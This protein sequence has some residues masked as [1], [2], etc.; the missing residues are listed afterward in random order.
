MA[1]GLPVVHAAVQDRAGADSFGRE[2][3]GSDSSSGAG[4]ADGH[5]QAAVLELVAVGAHEP[6][7]DVPAA[8]DVA[9]VALVLLAHVEELDRVRGE[10]RLELLDPDRLEPLRR[11][12]LEQVAA[13][14]EQPDR[15]Q[16]LRRELG[17]L[18]RGGMQRDRLLRVE[19]EAGLRREGRPVDAGR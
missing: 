12:E 17:L 18:V 14:V 8:G 19:Q 16:A 10:Q 6:V 13:E 15:P 11:G 4:R 5:D 3:A 1:A 2:R 7:G 9:L